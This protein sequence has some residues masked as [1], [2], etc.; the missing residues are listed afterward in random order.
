MGAADE[1]SRD[2]KEH[3]LV[4][5]FLIHA[6]AV[7]RGVE[8]SAAEFKILIIDDDPFNVDFLE[9]ELADLGYTTASAQNGAQGLDLVLQVQP[10]LVLLDIMMPVMDGFTVLARLKSDTQT[11]SIPV[12]II[13]ALGDMHSITKGIEMGAEDFLPKPF[14]PVLLRARLANGLQ[15]RSW[16]LQEQR[17]LRQIEESR[18]RID[19]LLHV[20]LP[21]PVVRE[22]IE[23]NQVL[24]RKFT[25]VAV[26]FVDIV[27]FTPYT[28]AHPVEDVITNLQTLVVAYEEMALT[29]RLQKIKTIGDSFM[30]AGG[31]LESLENP[32]MSC[33]SCGQE[34]I[35]YA[36][37]MPVGWDVRV[38]VNYGPLIAGVVG[39]RQYLYDI[40]GDTVNLA[41]RVESYGD[42]GCVNLSRAA[43][44]KVADRFPQAPFDSRTVKGKGLVDIFRI[45][46]NNEPGKIITS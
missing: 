8:V 35:A 12:V 4:V 20:I 46:V 10:D 5:I 39:R 37:S 17:Y 2:W 36:Q 3:S 43:W 21:G 28:E 41:H 6:W 19:D 31:L 1:R 33:V 38:G 9:Q 27:Q 45:E 26:L 14:D 24:P 15:K 18:Q 22:L 42:A 44:E 16:Q 11:R 29:W 40:W 30:A 23:Q 13:S 32:V 34:M 25:G 7:V